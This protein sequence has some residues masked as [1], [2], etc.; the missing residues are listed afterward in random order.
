MRMSSECFHLVLIHTQSDPLKQSKLRRK[1]SR[2]VAPVSLGIWSKNNIWG[3]SGPLN[4]PSSG[5][6]NTTVVLDHTGPPIVFIWHQHPLLPSPLV[7]DIRRVDGVRGIVHHIGRHVN[8]GAWTRTFCLSHMARMKNVQAQCSPLLFLLDFTH[9]RV[10]VRTTFSSWEMLFLVVP[11]KWR[12]SLRGLEQKLENSRLVKGW[13][14]SSGQ[15][16]G[17]SSF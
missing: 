4:C 16:F 9:K 5:S 7:P 14:V 13:S 2:S 6:K 15:A 17:T 10:C 3:W 11:G 12:D 8:R 1:R